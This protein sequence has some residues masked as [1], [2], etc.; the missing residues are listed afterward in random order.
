[1]AGNSDPHHYAGVPECL[2]YCTQNISFP[3]GKNWAKSYLKMDMANR[4]SQSKP[5]SSYGYSITPEFWNAT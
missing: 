3:K 4:G 5:V 1:M 2:A